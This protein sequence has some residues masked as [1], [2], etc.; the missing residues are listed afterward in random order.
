MVIRGT[1]YPT[2][3]FAPKPPFIASDASGS[4]GWKAIGALRILRMRQCAALRRTDMAALDNRNAEQAQSS[5]VPF[6]VSD[7]CYSS[8]AMRSRSHGNGNDVETRA[9]SL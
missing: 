9:A 3:R 1:G 5:R 6:R 2:A 4:N 8:S 7:Q